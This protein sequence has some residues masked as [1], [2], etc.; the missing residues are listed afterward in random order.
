MVL[1]T[2]LLAVAT[3]QKD[4]T[5]T[6]GYSYA[7]I[8]AMGPKRWEA[9]VLKKQGDSTLATGSGFSVY[10]DALAWRNDRLLKGR[11]FPLRRHLQAFS[12]QAQEVGNAATGGGTI[13]NIFAGQSY[14]DMEATI[15]TILTHSYRGP[16]RVVSDVTRA[17][18]RLG[19]VALQAQG[20]DRTDAGKA[21]VAIRRDL[22]AVVSDARKLPRQDSDAALEFCRETALAVVAQAEPQ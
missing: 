21:M 7:Q 22:A 3:L 16:H 19:G 5:A 12:I 13:W 18:D 17:I 4:R 6:L 2:T 10:G 20:K 8:L 15:H 11:P 14:R 9:T 1:F